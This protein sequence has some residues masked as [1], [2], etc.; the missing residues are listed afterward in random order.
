MNNYLVIMSN[1]LNP[2]NDKKC[3][4]HNNYSIVAKQG[5]HGAKIVHM[6]AVSKLD[7]FLS[8][9][10]KSAYV[11]TYDLLD[12]IVMPG[13]FDTHFHWVQ[14]DVREMPKDNL[15][16]WLEN[17][18]WPYESNFKSKTYA[19]K[20]AKEFAH[21]LIKN[22]T[23]GGA[24][25][26]SIHDH[27]VIE[28]FENFQGDFFI[29][30]VL[31]TMNSPD[32]LI[33][34]PK[35]AIDSIKR[36]AKKYK[37]R[38]VMTPRFAITTDDKT[39][40]EGG[41]IARKYNSFIQ[42][43]LSETENEIDFV[44]SIY[45]NIKGFEDVKTYTEI[46]DRCGLLGH[47][48]I[49]GHGIYL[50]NKELKR[51]AETKTAVAHCPTSNAPIK[52]RGLGS[53]L[54]DYKKANRLKVSWSLASDI[55]GGPFLSMLDV[56]NSFVSQNHLNGHR[57]ASFTQ[58]LY[59]S[60]L[61]GAKLLHIDDKAGNFAVGKDLSFVVLDKVRMFASDS[62]EDF[63][64]RLISKKQ[65]DRALYQEQIVSTCINGKFVY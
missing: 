4:F 24:C 46:Y 42:T 7:S 34:S 28:A 62:T 56:M 16:S 50:S 44:L 53:G 61:A 37:D 36:L 1:F 30:N 15:L 14:D 5:K 33:Q 11:E 27:S 2:L 58:A 52:Q 20:K 8:G 39:M 25:Y 17:Y 29:G 48:T 12:K 43:H 64:K 13:F 6:C 47:K 26:G 45:R 51:L 63:L 18:T 23:I 21:S 31:M 3:D 65:K 41:K 55:G 40:T 35:E 38:Y 32:Y 9:L 10:P 19:K 59:R 60:T 57:D 49:M 22:G 54:F